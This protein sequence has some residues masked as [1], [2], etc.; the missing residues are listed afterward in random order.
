MPES[1][2]IVYAL[3]NAFNVAAGDEPVSV[4]RGVIAG[5]GALTGRVG[6][7]EAPTAGEVLLVDAPISNP[8][9]AG[10]ALIDARGN[11]VGLVGREL[12]NAA[13]ETWIHYAIPVTTLAP[14]VATAR[15]G[16]SPNVASSPSLPTARASVDLRGIVPLPEWLDRTPPYVDSVTP[17]SP[18]A[19]AGLRSDDLVMFAGDKLIGSVAELRA[20]LAATSPDKP[21]KLTVKRGNGLVTAPLKGKTK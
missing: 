5:R 9:S 12:R 4:Q 3:T 15:S 20:A 2:D 10:G 8:G 13:T 16:A 18:A 1:G 14:F 19:A 21:I 7:R 17:G 6:V 11:L